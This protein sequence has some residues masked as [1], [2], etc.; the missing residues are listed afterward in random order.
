M[1]VRRNGSIVLAGVDDA[2]PAYA[3]MVDLLRAVKGSKTSQT[4]VNRVFPS[5]R[6]GEPP[7]QSLAF[8]AHSALA[9]PCD[10]Q[11]CSH[12]GHVCVSSLKY[13]TA[14]AKYL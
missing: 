11:N 9:R 4:W 14:R 2:P 5:K 12:I 1:L 3:R 8:H 13:L 10:T 6:F 7:W